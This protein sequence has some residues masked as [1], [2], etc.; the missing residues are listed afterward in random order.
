MKR[1]R[2]MDLTFNPD[3]AVARPAPDAQVIFTEGDYSHALWDYYKAKSWVVVTG[4][5]YRRDLEGFI[6]SPQHPESPTE[7]AD[8][9]PEELVRKNG[10]VC[11]IDLYFSTNEALEFIRNLELPVG[12]R[13]EVSAQA[14]EESSR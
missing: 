8:F 7:R 5:C 10:W 11:T 14:Y 3:Q 6:R 13:L 1:R 2:E 9:V 12:A 4:Q